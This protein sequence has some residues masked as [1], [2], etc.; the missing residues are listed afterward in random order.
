MRLWILSTPPPASEDTAYLIG[1]CTSRA[2]SVVVSTVEAFADAP[3]RPP[4]EDI[5]AILNRS[6][7]PHESF[8]SGL[9]ALA[10]ELAVPVTNPGAA[11]RRACDKRTYIED[12]PSVIPQTWVA[13]SLEEL[14][15]LQQRLGDELVI[16][17]PFGKH[18]KDIIRFRGPEDGSAAAGLLA[19]LS[20]AGVV[21]QPFC[22]GFVEGDKRIILQ[23]A[24]RGGFEIVAWFKR[25]PKA[26]GWK[27]NVSA[28]GHIERCELR[29][30]E[31][32]LA[33]A[34]AETA[35]LDCIG[36][37]MAW[38]HGRCLLIETNG[39]TGGHI[40][41]DTDRRVHSGDSFAG[42]VARL[43]RRGRP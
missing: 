14:L 31:K 3:P 12:F 39:Y 10:A 29:D 20:D 40:D 28:G 30:A 25:V 9:D 32:D 2:S 41:F 35:G 5:D 42:M 19:R 7:N 37:D 4:S 11:T 27:S 26:G 1:R 34:V 16:K 18:G 43:A 15:N 38:H 6:F 21:A 36:I 24:P 13:H 33:L 17:D 23:R 8:L 22:S